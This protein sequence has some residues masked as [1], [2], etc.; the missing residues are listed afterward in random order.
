MKRQTVKTEFQDQSIKQL[1]YAF[2]LHEKG[3]N[4]SFTPSKNSVNLPLALIRQK[5]TQSLALIMNEA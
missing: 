5:M 3:H 4:A 1:G 2:H